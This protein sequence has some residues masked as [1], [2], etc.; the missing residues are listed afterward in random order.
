MAC[1]DTDTY[2]KWLGR[3]D[4]VGKV[5]ESAVPLEGRNTEYFH[6]ER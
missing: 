6:S 4:D 5:K 3:E 1:C 2:C